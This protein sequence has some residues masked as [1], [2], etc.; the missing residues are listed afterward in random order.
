[1]RWVRSL[2]VAAVGVAL[3]SGV[4][5]EGTS[6]E[7]RGKEWWAHVQHLADDSMRGRL[8]GSEDYLKAAAYVVDKFKSYGLQPAGV[9]GG[10]YQPVKFDV[11][12]VLADRSSMSLVV[13]GKA[14]PLV[15]GKDAILGSRLAQVEQVDAPL[16]FI[17]YGLHLPEAK[18][19]DFDSPEVSWASLKGKVVVY[20][21]GGPADLPGPLKS[22]ARTA[23]FVKALRDSGA[24]G[25]I[26]IP[27]PKSMDF[28]WERVASSASQPGMRLAATPDAEAVAV[29]HPALAD[30]HGTMFTASFNPAE[31]EKLFA[32]TGHTFAEM[33]ALAD[34]Q[35]PM[36]RFAL[37]KG[38]RATVVTERSTV[39]SPNIVAK[40]EGSDPKLKD[41]Y[42]VVSAHLDHLGVGAPI[43]GKTIYNG[44]MDDASG[45]A[46]VLETAK[47]FSEAKARP[48][49]SILFVVF[50]AEEK[51][52]LGSRYFAGHPTVPE[53]SIKAALNLDM[54]MPIFPLKKLHVQGLEQSTLGVDAK[55]VGE[56]HH[57]VVAGD[58]EPDRNSFIRT[59][60]YSFVQ[61]GVAALAF[62]F[63]WEPGSPEYKAWRG[64]LAE[65]YHS[66]ADDL[67][68]PVDL[69]AAAQFNSF[70]Y[71]LARTVADDPATQHY[72]DT[73]FFKR[74]EVGQ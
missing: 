73:S 70:Y 13:D 3:A 17:G 22:Y 72:L 71:D 25:A 65:R 23:P 35:K 44:A 10:F 54:F 37:G 12:R 48:K 27:T 50:T 28:G 31:A 21:N 62:K 57:I 20:I 7:A 58:P 56:A 16:I 2:C 14:Q 53:G 5:A 60:Q 67:S 24:V 41:E 42:I 8:T 52:L 19:D 51:G 49:R 18:Y 30:D 11:Q 74:F 61:A 69:V 47:A 36:P 34:A 15:L 64:W 43:H 4:L 32:G 68:Q 55:K 33:L 1:M 45:V 59:D 29:R 46:S 26:A 6:D 38:V 39:E 40:L 63:G 9:N 66:T